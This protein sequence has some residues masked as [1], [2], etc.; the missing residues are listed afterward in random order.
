MF[1]FKTQAPSEVLY[2][3]NAAD[4]GQLDSPVKGA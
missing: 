4:C 2:T 1:L 3:Q